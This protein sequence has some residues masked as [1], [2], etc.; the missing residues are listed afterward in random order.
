MAKSVTVGVFETH[1]QAET[2][3]KEHQG[4][5]FDMRQFLYYWLGL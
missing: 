2:A 5:H 4:S 1:E 3:I